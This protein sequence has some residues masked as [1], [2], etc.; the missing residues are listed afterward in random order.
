M[1]RTSCACQSQRPKMVR[2][3]LFVWRPNKFQLVTE[4]CTPFRELAKLIKNWAAD[5]L[6]MLTK[7]ES[8]GVVACT[9]NIAFQ[10]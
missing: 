4:P 1:P 8:A 5:V 10:F 6:I 9:M 7:I 2:N 3:Q